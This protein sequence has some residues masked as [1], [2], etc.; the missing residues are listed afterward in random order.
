MSVCSA[1]LWAASSVGSSDGGHPLRNLWLKYC[2]SASAPPP[3]LFDR[4]LSLNGLM[5]LFVNFLIILELWLSLFNYRYIYQY[6]WDCA[7]FWPGTSLT[8]NHLKPFNGVT[9]RK[10]LRRWQHGGR[11]ICLDM[12][13]LPLV[14]RI[15]PSIFQHRTLQRQED[16]RFEA[17][18]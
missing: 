2:K 5:V 6:D 8:T 16:L 11:R 9:K 4:N 18:L 1:G 13:I 14:T 12:L 3:A 17:Q 15:L 10:H 7:L